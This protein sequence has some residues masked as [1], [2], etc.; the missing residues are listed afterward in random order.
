MRVVISSTLDD[1]VEIDQKFRIPHLVK[2]TTSLTGEKSFAGV[3]RMIVPN[4]SHSLAIE[5][6]DDHDKSRSNSVIYDLPEKSF[7]GD[8]VAISD[9]ELSSSIKTAK[10]DKSN[11]FYKNALEVIPNPGNTYGSQLPI[12]Y[13][14]VEAYNLLT[15]AQ[16]GTYHTKA[17]IF[18]LNNLEVM[19]RKTSKQRINESSVEVGKLDI[20]SLPTG[21]YRFEFSL[22]DPA[23]DVTVRS[24]KMLNVLNP[25]I[26]SRKIPA[27]AAFDLLAT[28]YLT[29]SEEQLD[30]EFSTVR[31][32]ANRSEVSAYKKLSSLDEKKKFLIGFWERRD[33][34]PQTP[35]NE[36]RSEY[37][38]R[39]QYTNSHFASGFKEGWNT[40]R[41]RV[42][43]IYGA[44][45]EYVR[46][47][48]EMGMKPFEI[49]YYHN[50]QGG[51]MFVFADLSGFR[52]Y[53]LI[54]ST[55]RNEMQDY[56]W[57]RRVKMY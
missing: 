30:T 40:D 35:A 51:V 9:V 18:D 36:G 3:I 29:K 20:G 11:I 45:D 50:I 13:F 24:Q 55:H 47:P 5:T 54:H 53:R 34:E 14:Y 19:T 27:S 16:S 12:L 31:Y 23:V 32:I 25:D 8:E 26:T 56:D 2:D 22:T 37:I 43:V 33:P 7:E 57:Q 49:W 48:S 44:P 4:G 21:V 46:E 6:F 42:F 38:T 41:G 10:K 28:E 1:S 15:A 17:A 39:V 52:D